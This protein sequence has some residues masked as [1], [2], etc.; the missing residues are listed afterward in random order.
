MPK[1]NGPGGEV[2]PPGLLLKKWGRC[3]L[4]IGV[5][6]QVMDNARPELAD[7][8]LDLADILPETVQFGDHD[9]ITVRPS[10]LPAGYQRPGYD[11]DQDTDGTDYLSQPS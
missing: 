9:F 7:V 3:I 5:I 8:S 6:F 11:D 10:I 2:V 4:R 1:N